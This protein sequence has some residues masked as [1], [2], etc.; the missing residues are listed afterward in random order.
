M[1]T[2]NNFLAI[3]LFIPGLVALKETYFALYILLHIG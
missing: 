2:A 3:E 1:E